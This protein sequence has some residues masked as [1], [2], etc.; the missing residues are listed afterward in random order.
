MPDPV[1]S[2]SEFENDD[3]IVFEVLVLCF[4]AVVVLYW[5]W[6]FIPY[7]RA[8]GSADN[9]FERTK[10]HK[11][12][13]LILPDGQEREFAFHQQYR[14]AGMGVGSCLWDGAIILSQYILS[15]VDRCERAHLLI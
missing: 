10:K 4:F 2:S 14:E 6:S 15:N 7:I 8:L 11:N 13:K 1:S 3:S 9:I 12:V 5:I